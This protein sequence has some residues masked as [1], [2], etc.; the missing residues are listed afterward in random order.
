MPLFLRMLKDDEPTVV[1]A[2]AGAL[3]ALVQ[4]HKAYVPW[5]SVCVLYLLLLFPLLS[6]DWCWGS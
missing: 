1:T 6:V 4:G 2:A 3:H 5:V